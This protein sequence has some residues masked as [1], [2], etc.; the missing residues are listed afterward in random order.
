MRKRG[1]SHKRIVYVGFSFRQH[2]RYSG[3]DQIRRYV[4]YDRFLDVD[5]SYRLVSKL[6]SI[7][8]FKKIYKRIFG[9]HIWWVELYLIFL[10]CVFPHKYVFHIIY[11]ENIYKFLGFFRSLC[12]VVITLHQPVS[13]FDKRYVD[14]I[15]KSRLVISMSKELET[16]FLNQKVNAVYLPHGVDVQ[17]FKANYS[18]KKNRILLVGNW[19]RDFDF[20]KQ[21]FSELFKRKEDVQICVISNEKNLKTLKFEKL[22][23]KSKISDKELLDEYNKSKVVFL[24]LSEYTA[25]NS[26][27]EAI[28][29]GCRV[30]IATNK[31]SQGSYSINERTPFLFPKKDP[32][33]IADNLIHAMKS[34]DIEIIKK[35]V[36]EF[37]SVFSWEKIG[38][39]TESEI[40]SI[41]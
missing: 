24:P 12:D 15:R 27:L 23:L 37:S 5:R 41:I 17:Y 14:R 11:G 10:A 25:N 3:Y 18:D 32:E 8:F 4:N 26:V 6:H 31:M 30:L 38:C 20:A 19:L 40:R 1:A 39:K 21:V 7:P 2:G 36:D 22:D 16:F 33:I 13:F 29:S 34:Y 9:Y 28:A 35:D